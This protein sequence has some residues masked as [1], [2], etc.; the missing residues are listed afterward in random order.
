[1]SL[2]STISRNGNIAFITGLTAALVDPI[3]ISLLRDTL[4]KGLVTEL[5]FNSG[6]SAIL[7]DNAAMRT[8]ILQLRLDLIDKKNFNE[9]SLSTPKEKFEP[10]IPDFQDPRFIRNRIDGIEIDNN[11][12]IPG[13]DFKSRDSMDTRSSDET[14]PTNM[15]TADTIAQRLSQPSLAQ[16]PHHTDNHYDSLQAAAAAAAAME[17]SANAHIY[18]RPY[19]LPPFRGNDHSMNN[20]NN[21]HNNNSTPTNDV[22]PPPQPPTTTISQTKKKRRMSKYL[23]V[24]IP[25][26]LVVPKVEKPSTPPEQGLLVFT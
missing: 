4:H 6:I 16:M 22:T 15:D 9:K 21:N 1:M 3:V 26:N 14:S 25:Q 19:D 12:N 7:A 5:S 8:E 13:R 24:A 11:M 2:P 23:D 17:S 10:I 18:H 20:N